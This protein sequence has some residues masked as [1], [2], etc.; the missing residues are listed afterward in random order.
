MRVSFYCGICS[1]MIWLRVRSNVR[2]QDSFSSLAFYISI[3]ETILRTEDRHPGIKS[4]ISMKYPTGVLYEHISSK[5]NISKTCS[6]Q[7]RA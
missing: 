7:L 2:D 4:N 6:L 1:T 5:R 3:A